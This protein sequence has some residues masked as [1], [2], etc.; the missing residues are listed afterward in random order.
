[1]WSF[2]V[3]IFPVLVYCAAKN[4]A[5]LAQT[6]NHLDHSWKSLDKAEVKKVLQTHPPI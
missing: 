3:P 2:C 1:L 6:I 4:L 5:S